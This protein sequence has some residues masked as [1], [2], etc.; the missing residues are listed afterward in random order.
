MGTAA[1]TRKNGCEQENNGS[2][3]GVRCQIAINRLLVLATTED[4]G[5]NLL[6]LADCSMGVA[7]WER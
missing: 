5:Q 4:T 1:L 6:Y 3:L 7:Q 2:G